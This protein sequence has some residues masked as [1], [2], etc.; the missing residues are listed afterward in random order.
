MIEMAAVAAVILFS[1]GLSL[2]RI[3]RASLGAIRTARKSLGDLANPQLNDDQKERIARQ[4]AGVLF[5]SFI[6]ITCRTAGALALAALAPL[7]LALFA[8][9]G[10]RELIQ[11]LVSWPVV[12]FAVV[13]SSLALTISR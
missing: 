2:F 6:S 8:E 10:T 13:A 9:L 11:A 12:V 3:K 7:C 4:S 1:A 5:R